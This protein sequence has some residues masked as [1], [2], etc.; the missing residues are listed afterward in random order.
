LSVDPAVA[1]V[2]KKKDGGIIQW[3][4]FLK[5]HEDGHCDEKAF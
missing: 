5:K 4:G 3:R 1:A 2:D